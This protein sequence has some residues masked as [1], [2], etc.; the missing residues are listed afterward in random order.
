MMV[1]G[2]VELLHEAP[3]RL[4]LRQTVFFLGVARASYDNTG[5]TA[6]ELVERFPDLGRGIEHTYSVFLSPTKRFPDRLG[7]VEARAD[8][9]DARRKVLWLTSKG[10]RIADKIKGR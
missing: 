10:R 9:D 2:L 6:S 8:P 3:S 7:W 5:I 4:S 1:E